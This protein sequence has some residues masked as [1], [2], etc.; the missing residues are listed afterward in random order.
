MAKT[1]DFHSEGGVSTTPRVTRWQELSGTQQSVSVSGSVLPSDE[2]Y[3]HS[4]GYILELI[5][6]CILAR[7]RIGVNQT[8]NMIKAL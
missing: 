8:K 2:R 1:S 7:T 3:V 6:G 4:S 5:L